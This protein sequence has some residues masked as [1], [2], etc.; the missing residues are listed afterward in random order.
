LSAIYGVVRFDGGVD[1]SELPPMREAIAY[2]GSDGGAM[3]DSHAAIGALLPHGESGSGVFRLAGGDILA[4]TA[5]LDNRADLVQ[6]FGDVSDIQL[7]ATAWEAWGIDACSRLYGDWSFA[8]W[9]PRER[10]LVVA[11]DQFGNTALYHHRAG[12]AFAFASSRKALFALPHIERRL[13][14]ERLVHHLA[15]WLKDAAATLHEGILRMP[16]GHRLIVTADGVRVEEYWKLQ[17]RGELHLGSDDAY[18]EGF[19][20]HYDAAV[21]ARVPASGRIATTLSSG[22]DSGSVTSL[23]AR[24]A[25]PDRVTAFTSVPRFPEIAQTIPRITAD[26]WPLAHRVA[27]H[28]GIRD[29]RPVTGI[30]ILEGFRRT[31]FLNDEP[32]FGAGN[33][34]WIVDLLGEAQRSGAAVLLTGQLGNGGVS[35]SGDQQLA[36]RSFVKGHWITAFRAV[37]DFQRNRKTSLPRAIS[38]RIARPLYYRAKSLAL[39]AGLVH[40]GVGG[41]GMIDPAFAERMRVAERM[42]SEGYDPLLSAIMDVTTQRLAALLPGFNP[43]GTI[44]RENGAGYALDVRDPTADVRLLEYCLSV[45]DDQFVRGDR[46]RWLIRRAVEGLLPPEAQWNVRRGQQGA[47]LVLRLRAEGEEIDPVV[48]ALAAAPAVREYLN[49]DLMAQHWSVIRGDDVAAGYGVVPTFVRMLFFS[50]FLA[51]SA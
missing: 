7:V 43:T 2:W 48:R 26:E 44:W 49:A 15:F 22:L 5:R 27:E 11:R 21:R 17:Q 25:G 39:R 45:P 46:D 18:V 29:H 32:H 41:S 51:E 36:V 37:R 12:N 40:V 9:S 33:L 31:L 47:D 23:A 3:H 42:R 16:P 20:A 28:I 14:E 1:G 24:A 13:N 30:S 35:W 10:R 8:A 50:M 4:A 38:A 6:Q 19:L 34:H